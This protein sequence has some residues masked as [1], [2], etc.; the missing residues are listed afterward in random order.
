[1]VQHQIYLF[2]LLLFIQLLKAWLVVGAIVAKCLCL[3]VAMA[4]GGQLGPADSAVDCC[5]GL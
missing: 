4:A 2:S 3:A 5:M 1:M